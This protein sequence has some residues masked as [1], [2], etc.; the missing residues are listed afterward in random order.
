MYINSIKISGYRIFDKE[1][2][3]KFYKGLNPFY[4]SFVTRNS[5]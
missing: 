4:N 1:T 3:I 5:V 2:E